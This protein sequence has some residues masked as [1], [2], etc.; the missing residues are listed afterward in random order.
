MRLDAG[1]WLKREMT[2]LPGQ[3]LDEM[4]TPSGIPVLI[5][6]ACACLAFW[7]IQEGIE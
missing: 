6:N 4:V 5:G 7:V 2:G 3:A 1:V